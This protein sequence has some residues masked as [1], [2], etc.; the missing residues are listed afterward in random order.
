MAKAIRLG[1]LLNGSGRTLENVL[2]HI[3]SGSLR[4]MASW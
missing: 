2:E 3:R 4:G 1:I